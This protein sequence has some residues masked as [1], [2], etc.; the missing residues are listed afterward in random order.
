[1]FKLNSDLIINNDGDLVL[2]GKKSYLIK[3][4][5][6]QIITF[7]QTL[8]TGINDIEF[9]AFESKSSLA[10]ILSKLR[11]LNLIIN[12]QNHPTNKFTSKSD[13]FLLRAFEI[14]AGAKSIFLNT[15]VTIIGC[16]G[17]GANL[18][19]HLTTTGLKKFAL[20]DPDNVEESNLNRQHPFTP[21]DIGK[22]KAKQLERF[23]NAI[24]PDAD[25]M[26][27]P[28]K[29]E[30]A[31]DLNTLVPP[32]DLIIC[33]ADTPPLTIRKIITEHANLKNIDVVFCGVGY[34]DI[35]IG[36]LLTSTTAKSNYI[37]SLCSLAKHLKLHLL[38]PCEG[39][40]GSTNS[41][42]TSVLATQLIHYYCSSNLTAIE[43][44]EL[45]IDPW[46][47]SLIR[48]TPYA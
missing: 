46:T 5:T 39:S 11:D 18:A 13:L 10:E 36:P 19:Y 45:V 37:E 7:F 16:G 47:L 32:T 23:I 27:I 25:V 40:L 14:Q 42:A 2:L 1:M 38:T 30:T 4:P 26:A 9:Q 17:V 22:S 43:N 31:S 12:I 28:T 6:N 8:R 35:S 41:I 48:E 29:I 21:A 44:T 33:G 24:H 15:H 3:N 20:I 34:E